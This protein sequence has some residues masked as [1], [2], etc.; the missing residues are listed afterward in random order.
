MITENETYTDIIKGKCAL[1]G[2]P[3]EK[4][5]NSSITNRTDGI[6]Y[7]KPDDKDGWCVFRC[8]GCLEIIEYLFVEV[9]DDD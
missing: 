2:E 6:R 3:H 8:R 5:I 7:G 9:S 4:I 1:C